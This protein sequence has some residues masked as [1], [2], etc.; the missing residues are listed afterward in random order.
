MVLL[1]HLN[2]FEYWLAGS[3]GL[4]SLYFTNSVLLSLASATMV[5]L[6]F[7]GLERLTRTGRSENKSESKWEF[8]TIRWSEVK[9]EKL[10]RDDR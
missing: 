7:K 5:W 1:S 9:D 8:K 4:V 6:L 10:G 3:M 2:H